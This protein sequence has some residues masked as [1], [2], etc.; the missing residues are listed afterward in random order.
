MFLFG[1]SPEAI[2]KVQ[3]LEITSKFI[4]KKNAEKCRNY[5]L[6]AQIEP[7]IIALAVI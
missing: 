1:F 3:L 6:I 7:F 5:F 4:L 2:A